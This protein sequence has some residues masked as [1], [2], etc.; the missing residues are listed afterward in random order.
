MFHHLTY[1]PRQTL[2]PKGYV[3]STLSVN[4]NMGDCKPVSMPM[5]AGLCLS[6][7]HD[8]KIDQEHIF[9]QSVNYGGALASLQYLSYT[10]H[11]D[12][13]YS[14][15]QLASFT[16]NPGVAHWS[17]I[18]HLLYITACTAGKKII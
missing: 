8:S 12:I 13:A 3:G 1:A 18:K 9:T 16:S 10:I 14:V 5:D 2:E 15:G 11:P 7:D 4:N 17:A 6:H